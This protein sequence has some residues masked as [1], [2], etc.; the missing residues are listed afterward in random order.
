[1]ASTV[2]LTVGV[3]YTPPS[4]PTN[5]GV[6]SFTTQASC[7]AQN[8]GQIDV[9]PTDAPSSLFPVPF[10]SVGYG[11]VVVIRNLMTTEVGVRL[12]GEVTNRF[13]LP[14][15]GEL[16]YATPIAP[17]LEPLASVTLVTTASP[18]NPENILYWVFGD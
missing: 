2:T 15:G 8:V 4:A 6:A 10:G 11:K 17:S 12:N 7:N 1:M 13:R 9:Q 14:A 16:V 3:Q 18:T 5:S